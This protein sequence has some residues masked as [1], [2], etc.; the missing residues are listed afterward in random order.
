MSV[1]SRVLR[2]SVGAGGVTAPRL[3][4]DGRHQRVYCVNCGRLAGW[5]TLPEGG[6]DGIIYICDACESMHGP[7]PLLRITG[8]PEPHQG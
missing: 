8:I 5:A 1:D 4:P 2:T 7:P 3:S 6:L